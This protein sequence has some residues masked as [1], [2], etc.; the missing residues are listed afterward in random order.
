MKFID[1]LKDCLKNAEFRKY[2]EEDSQDLENMFTEAR[3]FQKEL[4]IQEALDLLTDDDREAILRDKGISK[5]QP[6][7]L[8]TVNK[9]SSRIF[10]KRKK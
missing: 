3:H 8:V 1:H 2:W 10:L 9:K 6:T 7:G 5:D 4:T